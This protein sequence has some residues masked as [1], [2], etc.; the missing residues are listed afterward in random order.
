MLV[1]VRAASVNPHDWHFMRGLPYF[2][3]LVNGLRRPRKVTVL[4]CDVAG[5]VEEVGRAVTRFRPG[6][7]VFA[8]LDA[9]GFAE[10]A[11]VS[12]DLLEL[13]PANLTSEQAAALP[14]A[15]I[16]ALAGAS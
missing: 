3:R 10:Y 8:G 7:E 15:A 6:D 13:K 16:S 4:G 9:G 1:R 12:D 14:A 5:Q 2:V 11:C